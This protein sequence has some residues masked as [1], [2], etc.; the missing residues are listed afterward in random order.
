MAD[1]TSAEIY[2][3]LFERLAKQLKEI[4]AEADCYDFHKCQMDC[5]DALL[6]LGLA[7]KEPDGTVIYMNRTCNGWVG[8][9]TGCN[10]RIECG[11]ICVLPSGHDGE[12]ECS[13]DLDGPGSCPA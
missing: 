12:C 13:G 3:G 5:N 10:K 11:G 6:F 1:R 2:G 7:R 4:W 9:V 8:A